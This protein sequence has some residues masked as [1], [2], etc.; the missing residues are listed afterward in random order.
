M[1]DKEFWNNNSI[2]NYF[3]NKPSDPLIKD[4]LLGIKNRKSKK[5][6][7]LG[8]GAG[9]HIQLLFELGFDLFGCDINP[10]MIIASKKRLSLLNGSEELNNRIVFG[11]IKKLPFK[12][13][14]FDVI[15]TTGVIHQAKSL[16]E[17]KKAIKEISR[18]TKIKGI[19][20]MNV[21]TN[22]VWDDSYKK[23]NKYTVTTKEGLY[24]TLLPK[25]L[26]YKIFQENGFILEKEYSENIK[27][28]NTGPRSVL[29][30]NF[31]KDK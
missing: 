21:F 8:C 5:A 28:E 1:G 15:L 29:R 3:N 30:A 26:I 6:L 31:I 13:D 12:D 9:R 16:S 11:E 14:F 23:I 25:K 10:E 7:D 2:V 22:L 19:L 18:V 27:Q 17:Y 24:M 20:C 4:R